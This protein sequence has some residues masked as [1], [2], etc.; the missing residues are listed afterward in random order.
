MTRVPTVH[1]VDDDESYLRATGRLL[2]AQGLAVGTFPSATRLLASVTPA[3]RGCIVSDL[4]M[5]EIDGL[6][7]QRALARAGVHMPVVFLSG[8]GDIPSTVSAMQHG[9]V[10]FIE[11]HAPWE[12]LLSAIRRALELD[13]RE[14]ERRAQ[15]S[16]LRRKCDLLTRRQ[17]EVLREIVHGQMNK[18]IA[19]TLGI[20]E[21]TVKL[22]RTAVK[23][24]LGA[25][26][27]AQLAALARD[28]GL[29]DPS[30]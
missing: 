19:A 10:D 14:H 17:L 1:L 25:R 9:A 13:E 3:S 8:R 5:P 23:E 4:G 7:L 16:D 18:Q 15:Q 27:S 29:F 28:A 24:K 6:E 12:Q 21:R 22:H 2:V 20:S 30:H 11:K 26:T